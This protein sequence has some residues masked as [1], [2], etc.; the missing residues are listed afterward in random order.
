MACRRSC[1]I[2]GLLAPAVRAA[3]ATSKPLRASATANRR[4]HGPLLM[5]PASRRAPGPRIG[6]DVH[7]QTASR[8]TPAAVWPSG[9]VEDLAGQRGAVEL[10]ERG[11]RQVGRQPE[12]LG[13]LVVG[14]LGGH[15]VA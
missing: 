12:V 5:V 15:V 10:V 11:K 3:T 9:R 14:D 8:H 1:V 6:A 4:L 7:G 2:P 13:E